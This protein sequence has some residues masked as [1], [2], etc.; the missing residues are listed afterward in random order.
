[1]GRDLWIKYCMGHR[2]CLPEDLIF[3]SKYSLFYRRICFL[4]SL[5]ILLCALFSW[6]CVASLAVTH[7]TPIIKSS[8]WCTGARNGEKGRTNS[9]RS[10]RKTTYMAVPIHSQYP[11]QEGLIAGKFEAIIN[12]SSGFVY[13][14]VV[15]AGFYNHQFSIVF[16]SR[17]ISLVSS[18][19][20]FGTHHLSAVVHF[21]LYPSL[22][23]ELIVQ[24]QRFRVTKNKD[25]SERIYSCSSYNKMLGFFCCIPWVHSGDVCC[26]MSSWSKNY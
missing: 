20:L 16:F 4:L 11:G 10:E 23:G 18:S 9:S 24:D 25:I 6:A 2:E 21:L 19:K 3:N 5:I 15:I 7:C 26:W 22:A 13:G 12:R 14:Y 17:Q 8:C 1:M